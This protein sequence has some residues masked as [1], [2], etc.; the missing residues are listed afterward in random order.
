MKQNKTHLF[1]AVSSV[2]LVVM[3][4]IQVNWILQTAQIKE[5][6]FNDKA[7]LVLF[8]NG[9]SHFRPIRERANAWA[10]P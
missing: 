6:L 8:E 9:R 10:A 2:A 3:L 1:I 7:N 5:Q 4:A